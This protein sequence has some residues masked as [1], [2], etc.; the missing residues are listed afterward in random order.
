MGRPRPGIDFNDTVI[1]H[2]KNCR[3]LAIVEIPCSND[4]L[5]CDICLLGKCNPH[6]NN[7][8]I[9]YIKIATDDKEN[10]KRLEEAMQTL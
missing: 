1:C 7:S 5:V 2:C 3:C 6:S 9:N 8:R 4:F 10:Q